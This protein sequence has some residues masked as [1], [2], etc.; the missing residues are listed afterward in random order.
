MR[1]LFFDRGIFFRADLPKPVLRD[2]ETLIRILAAGICQTDLEILKG[3]MG[4]RGIPGH[5]FVGEV[6]SPGPLWQKRVVGEINCPCGTCALCAS[7]LGNHCPQRTVLGIAGRDGCF[8]EYTALP[9]KN[10]YPLPEGLSEEKALFAEPLAA[11]LQITRQVCLS[12]REKGVVLGDGRLGMLAAQVLKR[13]CG[14]LFM[15]GRY[16]EKLGVARKL[17]IPVAGKKE[18][19][20]KGQADLVVD[21]TGSRSGLKK[22]LEWVRP[23]GTIVLKTTVAGKHTIDLSPV[24]IHEISVK[25][26]RCGPFPEAL[27][28]LAKDE[29]RVAPLISASFPLSR[30]MEAFRL[31]TSGKALKVVLRMDPQ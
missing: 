11:A 28:A 21:A 3:Y 8:S 16:R 2:G 29:V 24:V 7:G 1:G 18:K 14:E 25:G 30:W 6:V 23:R 31:A 19:R 10:L 9:S 27:D 17:G 13:R 4:F 15:V 20:L 12:G 22:A 5:E 26:S